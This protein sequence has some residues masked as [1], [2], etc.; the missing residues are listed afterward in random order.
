[1]LFLADAISKT[2]GR[3]WQCPALPAAPQKLEELPAIDRQEVRPRAICPH[4]LSAP[5]VAAAQQAPT[6][7]CLTSQKKLVLGGKCDK[8][9]GTFSFQKE[10][11]M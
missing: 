9:L 3:I 7:L 2:E 4:S 10:V 5:A 6:G 8:K 1:M 11:W